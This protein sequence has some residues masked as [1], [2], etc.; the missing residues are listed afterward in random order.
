MRSTT[1]AACLL[2]AAMMLAAPAAQGSDATARAAAKRL[3]DLVVTSAKAGRLVP[4]RPLVVRYTIAARGRRRA[5]ATSVAFFLSSNAKRDRA[6]TRLRTARVRTLRRGA[7]RKGRAALRLPSQLGVQRIIVCVDPRRRV[8]ETR[9]RNNCRATATFGAA[10]ST[11]APL[12]PALTPLPPADAPPG[13]PPSGDPPPAAEP[14]DDDGDSPGTVALQGASTT[15]FN[16]R[17]AEPRFAVS[18]A[19]LPSSLD[20]VRVLRNGVVVPDGQ[21]TLTPGGVTFTGGL[22]EGRNDLRLAAVDSEFRNLEFDAVVWAGSDT[23]IV[24]TVDESSTPVP[25]AGVKL[26]LG[27]DQSVG[28]EA[29]SDAQGDAQFHNLP[30]RTILI[31][32]STSGGLSGSTGSTGG[33]G[34]ASLVLYGFA[35]PSSVDNNDFSQGTAGWN[36]GS[37]PVSLVEHDPATDAPTRSARRREGEDM[38]LRL[39][40]S[41]E[42]EERISR[43]FAVEED[44]ESV[45]VKYRFITSEVPG[46]YF[47]TKYNDY[48]SVRVRSQSAGG[49]S[50]E[51]N[52]MNGLGLGAFGSGGTTAWREEE[53][54]VD[55][56]DTVQ[57][58]IAVANVSDGA[59]DSYVEVALI[60]EK[61]IA[62][63]SLDLRD[64]EVL[65]GPGDSTPVPVSD[66]LNYL[67]VGPRPNAWFDGYTRIWGTITITGQPDDK[68]TSLELEVIEGGKVKA[69]APLTAGLKDVLYQ[70]FGA[71]RTLAVNTNQHLFS[72]PANDTGDLDLV[73]N[74][75]VLVR[76]RVRSEKVPDGPSKEFPTRPKKLIRHGAPDRYGCCNASEGGDEWVKPTVRPVVAA[77]PVI[78]GDASNMNAGPIEPHGEH[79]TGNDLDAD[80]DGYS[81]WDYRGVQV[82]AG[83]TTAKKLIGW[84]NNDTFG[85]KIERIIVTYCEPG[86]TYPCQHDPS[87]EFWDAIKDVKLDDGRPATRVFMTATGHHHHFHMDVVGD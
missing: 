86:A 32:G 47:G 44:V 87:M 78:W 10:P 49:G 56:A 50:T 81:R 69:R 73:N 80:Y 23:L 75:S 7:R 85:S 29:T 40:T 14:R 37:A 41:G 31:Q 30:D 25:G 11:P 5:P 26:A 15:Q 79:E 82:V 19:T 13:D 53:L 84:L 6:D 36:V 66:P 55:G 70:A 38:D 4:G 67:S 57:V 77:I 54:N 83:A 17:D 72:L 59:L 58:D 64:T 43:T 51:A 71:D 27:D 9:E 20:F 65:Y 46:G 16:P 61:K 35:P 21:L 60:E 28:A 76:A 8:R 68:I 45:S 34:T 2:G 74:G 39:A 22:A 48:F 33:A 12:P 24:E 3:P 52:S 63:K 42:G 62:I 1:A 18:G